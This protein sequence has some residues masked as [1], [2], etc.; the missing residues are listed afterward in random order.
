M[1]QLID[2]MLCSV[3]CLIFYYFPVRRFFS[4]SKWNRKNE[5][6]VYT[7]AAADNRQHRARMVCISFSF[8][9]SLI[10]YAPRSVFMIWDFVAQ[11][12]PKASNWSQKRA[13]TTVLSVSVLCRQ[14]KPKFIENNERTPYPENTNADHKMKMLFVVVIV[15][16][17]HTG[18]IKN[19]LHCSVMELY[20]WRQRYDRADHIVRINVASKRAFH[21]I[22]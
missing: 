2:V 18:W 9:R 11:S 12:V 7:T 1:C 5:K 22:I 10:W 6:I 20:E 17:A 14:I 3:Q 4:L 19:H 21:H 16:H 13:F 8:F 15:A